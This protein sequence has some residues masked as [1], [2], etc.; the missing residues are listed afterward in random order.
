M[1]LSKIYANKPFKNIEFNEG[2]NVIV[3]TMSNRGNRELDSHSLGKSL[4]LEVIDFLL[5]KKVK[6][7]D[8]YF[9]TNKEWLSEYIFYAELKL[10]SGKYLIIKRAVEPNTRIAFKLSTTKIK[11]FDTDIK[12][13]DHTDVG[14][15]KAII[16]LNTYLNFSILKDWKYRKMI[17]YFMRYQNDYTDVFKLSKFQGV[18]KDWKP[19]V[20][21]LLGFNGSIFHE[22]LELEEQLKKEKERLN[23]LESE[24]QITS[25]DEDKVR[26]LIDIKNN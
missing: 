11:G 2:L 16:L 8:K 17:N 3:G 12:D 19:M 5:L 20:F 6:S 15:D 4:L 18:H 21:E 7:K 1:K 14:I 22:K 13:W 9:L 10:N 23:T 25:E 24:N 26:G